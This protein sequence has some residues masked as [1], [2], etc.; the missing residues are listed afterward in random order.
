M[1]FFLVFLLQFLNLVL[2]LLAFTLH[3]LQNLLFK[4]YF[5]SKKMRSILKQTNVTILGCDG[6]S[7][8]SRLLICLRLF[9]FLCNFTIGTLESNMTPKSEFCEFCVLRGY[10]L[11]CNRCFLFHLVFL[12]FII[13]CF[14][15]LLV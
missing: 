6:F 8:F 10:F 2:C 5:H 9:L 4:S 14:F 3:L 13:Y 7:L 12:N 11:F 1:H 15:F